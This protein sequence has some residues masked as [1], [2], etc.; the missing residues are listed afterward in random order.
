MKMKLHHITPGSIALAVAAAA[1]AG[2]LYLMV[3]DAQTPQSRT[4]MW[5]KAPSSDQAARGRLPGEPKSSRAVQ[6]SETQ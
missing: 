3:A 5:L 4:S 6:R 1:V 2:E